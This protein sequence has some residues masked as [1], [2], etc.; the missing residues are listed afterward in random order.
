MEA[1]DVR[2][3][4][5][6]FQH[7][8]ASNF[9]WDFLRTLRRSVFIAFCL[10]NGPSSDKLRTEKNVEIA[11]SGPNGSSLG[12]WRSFWAYLDLDDEGSG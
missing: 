10:Q 6:G 12:L 4:P 2:T 5:A 11:V 1:S 3:D 9:C 7:A 8:S